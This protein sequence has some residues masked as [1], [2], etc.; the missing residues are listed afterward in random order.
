VKQRT[1]LTL[2]IAWI[3]FA[4]VLAPRPLHAAKEDP[5]QLLSQARSRLDRGEAAAALPILD[6]L[7]KQEPKMA[8]AYQQRATARLMNG[9]LPGGKADLDKALSLDPGLRQAWLDRAAVA[10][11]EQRWEAALG[12]FQKARELDPANPDSHLNV[13]AM[14]L[15]LG[16]LDAAAQS[17][18]G[19]LAARPGDAQ[20]HY[21]VARNYAMGGYAGL[22][23]QSL[24]QAIALDERVRAAARADANFSE[25]TTNPRFVELLRVDSFRAPAGTWKAQ[26]TFEAGYGA[27][28]GPL[29]SATLDALH[30][31]RESYEPRL[32]VTPEWGLVWSRMRIKLYDDARG[33]GIVELTAPPDHFS[34]AEWLEKSDR[35]LDSIGIQLSKRRPSR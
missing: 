14:E 7:I 12:D 34:D 18:Q 25:L 2:A 35:L 19:Y 17:F 33:Q 29:L 31:L 8:V 1:S 22:A 32:E 5:V 16:R 27:G 15:L 9:D 13:G 11:A 30:A 6:K 4:T 26:R 24:Q 28:R 21:L 23:I 10:V 3:A 20:A